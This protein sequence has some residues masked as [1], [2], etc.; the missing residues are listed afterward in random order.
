MLIMDAWEKMHVAA[1]VIQ[2]RSFCIKG[3]CCSAEGG[4]YR[5]FRAFPQRKANVDKLSTSPA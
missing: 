4:G 5:G 3:F 1:V 2:R